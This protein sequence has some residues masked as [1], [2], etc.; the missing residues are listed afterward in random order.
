MPK[1]LSASPE[2]GKQLAVVIIA[3][4]GCCTFTPA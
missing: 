1:E 3:M 2:R 4:A